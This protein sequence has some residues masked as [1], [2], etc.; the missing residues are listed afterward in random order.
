MKYSIG[1][2]IVGTPSG[3]S[4][5]LRSFFKVLLRYLDLLLSDLSYEEWLLEICD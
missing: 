4:S 3:A 1:A 5:I 2:L